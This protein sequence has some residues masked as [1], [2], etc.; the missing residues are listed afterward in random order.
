METKQYLSQISRLDRMIKNKISEISQLRELLMSVS[1]VSVDE[2]V[3]TSPNFDKIGSSFCKISEMEDNLNL[4]IDEYVKKK[5]EIISQIE[6][7]EDEIS[8]EILFAR[9]IA[10]AAALTLPIPHS[11]QITSDSFIL[12][13]TAFLPIQSKE[14]G[15]YLPT[16]STKGLYS[17][18]SATTTPTLFIFIFILRRSP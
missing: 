9:Y 11:I 2:K 1:A 5:N 15:L 17:S 18:K 3:Q 6:S 10:A 14:V 4:L 16:A 8:Y 13:L 12:K 7:I